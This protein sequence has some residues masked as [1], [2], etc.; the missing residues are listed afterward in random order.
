MG[1]GFEGIL[2]LH[3]FLCA[4]N[5]IHPKGLTFKSSLFNVILTKSKLADADAFWPKF[6]KAGFG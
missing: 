5:T 4:F 6:N 2:G 3:N 1:N